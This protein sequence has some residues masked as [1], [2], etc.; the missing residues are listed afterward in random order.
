MSLVSLPRLI[1]F[2]IKR[3]G[4]ILASTPRFA[5]VQSASITSKEFRDPN[6]KK[7][8]P[9]P[10]K[11]KK[12]T[13][14]K[15]F[16][17]FT[18]KRFDENT[19]IIVVDG[20]IAAGKGPFA[21]Q[22]AEAFDMHYI[23]EVT[24]EETYLTPYGYDIRQLN[25]IAPPSFKICDLETYL[26]N[27]RHPNVAKMQYRWFMMKL[28]SYVDA[29]AHILNT[30]Q[31]IVMERSVYSDFVFFEAMFNA[32]YLSKP[33]RDLYYDINRVTLE[34]LMQ[35]HLIVYLDIS[36]EVVLERIKQRNN[37]IEV[38]S[39]VF[40]KEYLETMEYNYKQK[41]LKE[42]QKHSEILI[43]DWSNY[44]DVEVVVEDI[45]RIDFERFHEYDTKLRDWR[46]YDDWEWSHYR[47]YYTNSKEDIFRYA[48][49]FRPKVKEVFHPGD[50]VLEY[51]DLLEKVPGEKYA[52]GFNPMAGDNVWFKRH[53]KGY[54]HHY[55]NRI[56]NL[57]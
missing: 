32:G 23:P 42:Y 45:E 24:L 55:Y 21:K 41:Y 5:I 13:Y 27:P 36:P 49:I 12:F 46:K 6:I 10:Y 43:Y 39:P 53:H 57:P 28:D 31:G 38:N 44:G 18:T 4:F 11:T 25:P 40:T 22:L 35:P 52:E 51:R 48:M 33:V 47:R 30:G 2:E 1:S 17:D 54:W 50:E 15:A 3:C 34:E 16:Y 26:K 29:L 56:G 9:W 8:A 7:P 20:P 14:F 19:K 37:P